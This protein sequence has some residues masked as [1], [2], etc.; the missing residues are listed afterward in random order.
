MF[1]YLQDRQHYDDLYDTFTVDHCRT[2]IPFK[3]TFSMPPLDK[4]TRGYTPKY[5]K[6]LQ[7]TVGG[8]WQLG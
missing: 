5:I 3:L 2:T 1:T 6:E 4:R 8:E 7:T